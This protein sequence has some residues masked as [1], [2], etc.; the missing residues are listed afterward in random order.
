MEETTEFTFYVTG[1]LYALD[2]DTKEEEIA[3][4]LTAITSLT[5]EY[6]EEIDEDVSSNS[7][8][9]D[10]NSTQNRTFLIDQ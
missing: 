7:T 3:L 4:R 6:I 1:A 2:I 9:T 8:E 5:I 10:G